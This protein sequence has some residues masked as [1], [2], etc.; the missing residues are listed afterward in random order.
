MAGAMQP[1]VLET[2]MRSI[3]LS[4]TETGIEWGAMLLLHALE[5]TVW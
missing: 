3:F 1:S 4:A 5:T 2:L